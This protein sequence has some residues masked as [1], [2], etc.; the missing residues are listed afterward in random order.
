MN[1]IFSFILLSSISFQVNSAT[2]LV[3]AYEFALDNDATLAQAKAV[4][5]ANLESVNIAK[6]PLLPQITGNASYTINDGSSDVSD[7]N[8]TSLGMNLQQ[9][10]YQADHWARYN[11][12]KIK[13]NQSW[14]TLKITE[15]DMIIRV[16]ESYFGVLLAKED[17]EL[18]RVQEKANKNQWEKAKASE[19]VGLI[20]YTDVL[21][22]QSSYDLSKSTTINSQNNLDIAFEKLNKL[23]SIAITELKIMATTTQFE[24]E[25]LN[26][27]NYEKQAVEN[28][29]TVRKLIKQKQLALQEI[30]LQKSNYLPKFYLQAGY[31]DKKYSNFGS[32]FSGNYQDKT[33][34]NIGIYTSISLY[35]G[36]STTAKVSQAKA[37]EKVSKISLRDAKETAKLNARI[38]IRNIQRSH[39]LIVA[40]R[41]AVKSSD[42]FLKTVEEGYQVGLNNVLDVL[43]A[44]TNKFQSLRNLTSSLHNLALSKL[45][46]AKTLGTLD[47]EKLKEIETHLH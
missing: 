45:R 35:S 27:E 31:T 41:A 20:S 2:G 11:Q 14:L 36:G 1:R 4:H 38:A 21:Q 24:R 23:T 30:E 16:S 7:V 26:V 9:S 10:I 47:I 39:E 29:L 3:E 6:S 15:Q 44:R 25:E 46:L 18:S 28:N 32:N 34:L 8:T 19:E 12:S 42:A 5:A 22:T 17:L 43:T 40:N 13:L 37:N 33:N